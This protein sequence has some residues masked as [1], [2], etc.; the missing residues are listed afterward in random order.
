LNQP[1]P[2]ANQTKLTT[3]NLKPKTPTPNQKLQTSSFRPLQFLASFK[4]L[5]STRTKGSINFPRGCEGNQ[6]DEEIYP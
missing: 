1:K 6:K 3:P 2:K 4:T 5:Q